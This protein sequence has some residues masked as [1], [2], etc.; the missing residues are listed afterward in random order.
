MKK[1]FSTFL[2]AGFAAFLFVSCCNNVQQP[3]V[4]QT[5]EWAKKSTIYEV[6]VRQFTPEGTFAAFREHLPRLQ[7]LG[8]DIL[9]FM[10]I[11]PI[12]VKNRK[13]TLG[14]YYSVQCFRKINPE[15]GT[16]EE[17]KDLV[18]EIHSLGMRII[19]DFVPNHTAPDHRWVTENPDWYIWR[20]DGTLYYK[21]DWYDIAQLNWANPE[22]ADAILADMLFQI[23]EWNIDGF[24]QDVAGYVPVQFWERARREFDAIR[25]TFHLAEDE[26]FSVFLHR[27]FDAN[28]TWH[29][30]NTLMNRIAQGR[31]G[32]DVSSIMRW[33]H[34][35]IRRVPRR[36]FRMMFTSNHDENSW[37]GT[38]FDRMGDAK[39]TMAV[40]TFTFENSFP[41]IYNGQEAGHN[42]MLEF[43]ENDS[44]D[45]DG[46]R[47]ADWTDFYTTLVAMKRNNEALW[48]GEWGARMV[49]VNTNE[50]NRVLAFTREKNGNRV[51]TI[52]NMSNRPVTFTFEGDG[53]VGQYTEV[54]RGTGNY[55]T[56]NSG[57]RV[58]FTANQTMSMDAWS[59]QVL[60]MN[61]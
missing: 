27:A 34:E 23:T 10:P 25:P 61:F 41:L 44:I 4:P 53:F 54:I 9:W 12:G 47:A 1:L 2:L 42:R 51:F 48:N 7:A 37:A 18:R 55:F 24:R 14:S 57:N 29:L 8:V 45:W 17:F 3:W 21:H 28:Y 30:S 43:F 36:A 60:V 35:D 40:L 13:G 50:Q 33:H 56:T 19:L 26:N 32:Y 59:Y 16:E 11:H 6:N 49:R 31:P 38:E 5:P 22:V 39:A 20:E 46:P 52:M 58:T 15:F